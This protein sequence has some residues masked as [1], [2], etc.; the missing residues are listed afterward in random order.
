MDV[1][2]DLF[3]ELSSV[4]AT[5]SRVG[6]DVE[7]EEFKKRRVGVR[8]MPRAAPRIRLEYRNYSRDLPKLVRSSSRN[9]A[10]GVVTLQDVGH[11]LGGLRPSQ[12]AGEAVKYRY[13]SAGGLYP[14][15]TYVYIKSNV[16]IPSDQVVRSHFAEE[17]AY[18]LHP[19][20]YSLVSIRHGRLIDRS[21]FGTI[22]RPVF[23]QCAFVVFLIAD[24]QAIAPIYG[25]ESVRFSLI[26]AGLMAQLL[27]ETAIRCGVGLCH[28]GQFAPRE[29]KRIFA[30]GRSHLFL[31]CVLGGEVAPQT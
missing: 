12:G 20:E 27:D 14:V 19:D 21:M 29:L 25:I 26:E 17:G 23:D 1:E 22:N 2:P 9:F 11:L 4:L 5:I 10:S 16:T 3:A 15:Q 28:V 6:G 30:L 7:R 31:H 13:A 8:V 24:L 18:Y